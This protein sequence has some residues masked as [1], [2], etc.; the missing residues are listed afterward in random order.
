MIP[1]CCSLAPKSQTLLVA[2]LYLRHHVVTMSRMIQVSMVVN[3]ERIMTDLLSEGPSVLFSVPR[4]DD[5]SKVGLLLHRLQQT[6][7][8]RWE[9]DEDPLAA[10]LEA[11]KYY[12]KL[13]SPRVMTYD[14]AFRGWWS[15]TLKMVSQLGT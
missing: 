7:R 3:L 1:F 4:L 12:E 8:S 11:G 15:S 13:V 10:L 14:L 9:V 2:P 5:L 6:C